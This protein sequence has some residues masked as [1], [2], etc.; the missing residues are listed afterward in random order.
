MKVFKMGYV[1]NVEGLFEIV[2]VFDKYISEGY[3]HLEAEFG[4][5]R[6]LKLCIPMRISPLQS[7]YNGPILC[8]CLSRLSVKEIVLPSIDGFRNCT[9]CYVVTLL[10]LRITHD[11]LR[12]I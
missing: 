11:S 9:F 6:M 8:V 1:G 12:G 3:A 2:D 5:E 4:K 7:C 10:P